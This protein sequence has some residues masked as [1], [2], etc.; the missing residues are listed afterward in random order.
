MKVLGALIKDKC[1]EK[2]WNLVKSAQSG[3]TFSHLFFVDDLMLFAKANRKNCI[4]IRDVLD[5]FYSLSG[6]KISEEKSRVFFPPH[7]EQNTREELSEVLGFRS[8]ASLGKYLGF[9]IKYK[10]Q[11]QDFG[12]IIDCIQSKLA[13][14][15]ANLL[16]FASRVVLTQSVTS[17][18]PNYT[19]QCVA[20]PPKILKVVNRL[21]RNF[22]WGSSDS[23]KKFHLIGWNEITRDK[24]EGGLGIQA[25]KP[26]NTALLAKLNWGFK[27]EKASLWV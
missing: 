15:K 18:I 2:L 3:P 17:T 23:K 8:I 9:P 26:K 10:G 20:F 11:P 19:M 14:W 24:E 12:F 13:S 27:T 21:N 25:A 4:A 5:S 7:V 1:K 16:S 6:Q 22:I